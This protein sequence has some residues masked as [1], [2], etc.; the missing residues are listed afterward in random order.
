MALCTKTVSPS[1][2]ISPKSI[3]ICTA[4]NVWKRGALGE[5]SKEVERMQEH[6]IFNMAITVASEAVFTLRN[7][8]K[9]NGI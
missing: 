7:N 8:P 1:S 5:I 4:F 9:L 2:T 6:L 3:Q